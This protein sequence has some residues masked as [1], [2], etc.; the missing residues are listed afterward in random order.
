MDPFFQQLLD[1]PERWTLLDDKSTIPRVTRYEPEYEVEYLG[2]QRVAST[3]QR[4]ISAANRFFYDN[5]TQDIPFANGTRADFPIYCPSSNCT[6]PVYETL[7]VCS[8]CADVSELLEF[9]C[10]E[11]PVDWIA[12]TNG[13]GATPP[14]PSTYPTAMVCGHFLNSTSDNPVLVSG[15]AVN[16]SQAFSGEALLMRALPLVTSLKTPLYGNGSI[17]FKNHRNPIADVLLFGAADGHIGSVY[18]N[19]T[20]IALECVLSWC[21]KTIKSSY[22]L[23]RYT[24]EVTSSFINETEGPFPWKSEPMEVAGKQARYIEYLQPI[25]L[26][27]SNYT[28]DPAAAPRNTTGYQVSQKTAFNIANVF[29][30][31]FPSFVTANQSGVPL[32]RYATMKKELPH[33]KFVLRNPW[34]W[35]N[36]VTNHMERLAKALTDSMRSATETQDTIEGKAYEEE[37]YI[38]V[39]WA[40]LTLPIGLL[41]FSLIFLVWTMFRTYKQSDNL[42]VWK[43]SAIATLLYG[44]PDDM[45]KKI[46]TPTAP[47]ETPRSRAKEL[48]VKLGPKMGWRA[49]WFSPLT[50]K[51]QNQPPPGWI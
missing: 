45:Q 20:P 12:A 28:Q 42:G 23:A 22:A 36:N 37:T 24:E 49:S 40:W 30:D 18:R 39:R 2:N 35:P 26:D 50:P 11:T 27:V 44:L 9:K 29:K 31:I 10:M 46:K 7:G 47:G 25:T 43:T 8:A 19:D 3:D 14:N 33:T 34:L 15:Y 17:K 1:F 13:T 16:S 32:M 5:G 38:A 48:K 21:V 4:L 6:W 41:G 51:S